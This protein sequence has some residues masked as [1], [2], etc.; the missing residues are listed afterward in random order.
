MGISTRSWH[1]K[2]WE[3]TYSWS[4]DSP[5]GGV[6][7]W[8]YVA[9][10]IVLVPLVA[11]IILLGRVIYLVLS[12]A[13]SAWRFFWGI[14]YVD[15]SGCYVHCNGFNLGRWFVIFPYRVVLPITAV[16]VLHLAFPQVSL[17]VLGILIVVAG[18]V[19]VLGAWDFP[20][21]HFEDDP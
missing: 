9:R 18:L 19:V 14:G 7:L 8:S 6:S 5:P 20:W 1:Y 11:V 3:F 12:L 21:L 10:I 4:D 16:L 17:L 2:L 13:K 15:R